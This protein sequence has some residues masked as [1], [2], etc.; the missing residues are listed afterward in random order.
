MFSYKKKYFLI[1]KSIHD[2]NLNKI[3]ANNKFYLIYRNTEKKKYLV[4]Y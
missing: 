2:I 4:S 3:K 1:I